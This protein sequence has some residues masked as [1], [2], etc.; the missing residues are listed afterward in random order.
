LKGS[1]KFGQQGFE[2]GID[3][4][5]KK[6]VINPHL[7]ENWKYVYNMKKR[8]FD[9]SIYKYFNKKFKKSLVAFQLCT[10]EYLN[11]FPKEIACFIFSF[12][13]RNDFSRK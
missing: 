7:H 5:V 1:N 4:N 6:N 9:I 2:Q 10:V 8:I 12:L 3:K 11:I 13:G